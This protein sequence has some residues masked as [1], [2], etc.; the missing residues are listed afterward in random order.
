MD[1]TGLVDRGE[2][3]VACTIQRFIPAVAGGFVVGNANRPMST[4]GRWLNRKMGRRLAFD[5][6]GLE[7][8]R[9]E[10]D[11]V[12]LRELTAST[13]ATSRFA[14]RYTAGGGRNWQALLHDDI[15]D[16]RPSNSRSYGVNSTFMA[17]SLRL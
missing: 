14:L 8:T 1:F 17:A 4:V 11:V 13:A 15:L 5:S 16:E 12:T 2:E 7:F 9:I 3:R 10:H 6:G